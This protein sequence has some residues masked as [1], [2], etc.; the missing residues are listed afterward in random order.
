MVKVNITLEVE[1]YLTTWTLSVGVRIFLFFTAWRDISSA[2]GT[3]FTSRTQSHLEDI[4]EIADSIHLSTEEC[5]RTV[6]RPDE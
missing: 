6:Q 3:I 5:R 4:A 1:N 2:D